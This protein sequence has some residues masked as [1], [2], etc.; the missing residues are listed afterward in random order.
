MWQYSNKIYLSKNDKYNSTDVGWHPCTVEEREKEG[1]H[2]T[3]SVFAKAIECIISDSA[4]TR[5]PKL[6]KKNPM[7]K[8]LFFHH[9]FKG[10]DDHRKDQI[11]SHLVLSFSTCG[12][13][14]LLDSQ[15]S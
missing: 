3:A 15:A 8:S 5:L 12:Q 14:I 11:L 6:K 10:N 1:L 9:I 7:K 13:S 2:H 4:S